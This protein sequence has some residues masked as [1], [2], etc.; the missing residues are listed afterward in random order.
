MCFCYPSD[1]SR[2]E[3]HMSAARS[4][5]KWPDHGD[6]TLVLLH[7]WGFDN[8]VWEPLQRHLD[9]F[10]QTVTVDLWGFGDNA[11]EEACPPGGSLL[12]SVE[13]VLEL[14]SAFDERRL[15][16]VGA[17]RGG[18]VALSAAARSPNTFAAV[19][20]IC[21]TPRVAVSGD[22]PFGVDPEAF[23]ALSDQLERDYAGTIT[24]LAPSFWLTDDPADA[25]IVG[26]LEQIRRSVERTSNRPLARKILEENLSDDVR[27]LLPQVQ[28]PLLAIGAERDGVVPPGAARFMAE[29]VPRGRF[30]IIEGAGHLPHLTKPLLLSRVL[31]GFLGETQLLEP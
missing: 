2:Q 1:T 21:T 29:A 31:L 19:V 18:L 3:I 9:P 15:V 8:S 17:S 20:T 10:V 30:H 6:L 16:A 13:D 26:A 28:V 4:D 5:A 11:R 25:D 14:S 12:R 22:Y 24:A 27:S 23:L 7:G